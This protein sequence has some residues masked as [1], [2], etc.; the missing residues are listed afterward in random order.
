LGTASGSVTQTSYSAIGD[1]VVH[2]SKTYYL[3]KT[4]NGTLYEDGTSKA[5]AVF[6]ST[7]TDR[8]VL[9]SDGTN[10]IGI[11]DNGTNLAVYNLT[12][13][14]SPV[15]VGNN[16]ATQATG[17][18]FC[19]AVGGSRVLVANDNNSLS[20]VVTLNSAAV[21]NTTAWAITSTIAANLDNASNNSTHCAMTYGGLSGDNRTFY[22]VIDNKTSTLLYS[23]IDNTTALIV[24]LAGTV[25]STTAETLA[26]TA[27]GDVPYVAVDNS[28]GGVLVYKTT[29]LTPLTQTNG[30]TVHGVSNTGPIDIAVAAD[31]K[32]VGVA[33]VSAA[34]TTT[35]P[36]VRIFY[37]E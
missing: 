24:S 5:T 37:D 3:S 6:V 32:T 11:A 29:S 31:N 33:G 16:I 35:Y 36:A 12:T 30:S 1:S 17:D 22:M 34:S 21:D 13:A 26:I 25:L 9:D 20:G 19:G 14:A 27:V 18:Q 2:D 4:D 10:M 8:I 23:I 28:T 15:R 7:V